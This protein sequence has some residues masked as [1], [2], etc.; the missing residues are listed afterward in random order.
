MNA[1]CPQPWSLPRG[2]RGITVSILLTPDLMSGTC[3]CGQ[4]PKGQPR[5]GTEAFMVERPGTRESGPCQE[6][7]TVHVGPSLRRNRGARGKE[8]RGRS[9]AVQAAPGWPTP[10]V[11][12]GEVRGSTPMEHP[13]SPPRLWSP[14]KTPVG[15]ARASDLGS[16]APTGRPDGGLETP[17]LL[18]V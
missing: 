2:L 11:P 15:A 10:P 8:R 13:P 1:P 18:G 14:P 9:S 5:S 4:R 7:G 17:G 3:Q 16:A 6:A 12:G